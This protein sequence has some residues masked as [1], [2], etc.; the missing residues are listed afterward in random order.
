MLSK[1]M[2]TLGNRIRVWPRFLILLL[3]RKKSPMVYKRA[4]H[5]PLLVGKNGLRCWNICSLTQDQLLR[6]FKPLS[7]WPFTSSTTS[8][9]SAPFLPS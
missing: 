7:G 2:E 3:A 1:S 8:L 9:L 6:G 5:T 4:L